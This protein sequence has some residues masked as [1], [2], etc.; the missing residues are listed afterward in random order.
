MV[1]FFFERADI[2]FQKPADKLI[3]SKVRKSELFETN[4]DPYQ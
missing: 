1:D 3:G 4:L 2:L